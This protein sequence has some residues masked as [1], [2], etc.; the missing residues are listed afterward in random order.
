MGFLSKAVRAADRRGAQ[1]QL[2][3]TGRYACLAG[4]TVDEEATR[5]SES[6]ASDTP[7]RFGLFTDGGRLWRNYKCSF[8]WGGVR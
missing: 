5:V 6:I 7:Q 1:R 4:E 8:V 3:T 2:E